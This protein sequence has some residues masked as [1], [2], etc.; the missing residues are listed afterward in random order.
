MTPGSQIFAQLNVNGIAVGSIYAH[1]ALGL[2]LT[3]KATEL[4]NF[5]HGDMLALSA[6]YTPLFT[7][8][9]NY[10]STTTT[11]LSW[12]IKNWNVKKIGVIYQEGPF[13]DVVRAGMNTALKQARLTV[14]AETHGKVA[15]SIFHRKS[16]K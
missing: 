9:Q 5:A 1:V 2:V 8:I 11:G 15:T 6:S 16:Q 13:G 14:T 4:L 12:A 10:D 3:Y 7:T